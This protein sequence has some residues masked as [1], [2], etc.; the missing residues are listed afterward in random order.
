VQ[1]V[2]D[3]VVALLRGEATNLADVALDMEGVP[4][5]NARV[6]AIARTIP[7]GATITYGE[8]AKR[9]GEADARDVGQAMGQNPFAPIV[10]C[11]RVVA[12]GGKTGGFSAKGGVATKLRLLAIEG[13]PVDGTLPLFER[14][15]S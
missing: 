4:E 10:P 15:G 3:R 5:F 8:I 11:H 6:Y 14:A 13:T 9:L 2:I 12:A 7:A 1:Q